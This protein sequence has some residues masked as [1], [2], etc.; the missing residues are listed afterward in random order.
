[1]KHL[2]FTLIVRI[3]RILPFKK[4]F[5][6]ILNSFPSIQQKL[7][8]DLRYRGE[9]T[10][11]TNG[12]QFKVFN[13]GY[14]TIENELFW[15]GLGGW[16]KVS[17]R[18]WANLAVDADT[19]LDIGANTGLYSLVAS[20]INRKAT[21]IAFEPVKRTSELFIKNLKL[22]PELN[23]QLIE[24]AVSN[25]NS[26]AQFYDLETESQYSASL[27]EDML[28][29][30]SNRINYEVETVSLDTLDL[31]HDKKIDL[32]KLDVEMHEPEAI[33]GMIEL[34]RKNRPYFLIEILTDAI[35]VKIQEQFNQLNYRYYNI[36]EVKPP[37]LALELKASECYNFLF[38]PNEKAVNFDS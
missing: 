2:I 6:K 13:P 7:Y 12:Y 9:M 30:Y 32:I 5:R 34:I 37:Q 11:S 14:T 24:K 31:L 16:E 8:K 21:V 18:I 10:V 23:I 19:I 20:S 25:R 22:N 36:D 1:M 28:A 3:W 26:I 38:I 29:A 15:N 35:A 17:M 27:N 4:Y 33:E